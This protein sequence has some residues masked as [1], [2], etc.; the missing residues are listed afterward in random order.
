M[1]K[2]TAATIVKAVLAALLVAAVCFA[3]Y[4]FR[5]TIRAWLNELK[6]RGD[7]MLRSFCDDEDDFEEL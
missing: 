2:P 6:A 4:Y 7:A 5:N 1:K 3:V